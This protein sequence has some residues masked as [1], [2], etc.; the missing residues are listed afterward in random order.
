VTT[1]PLRLRQVLVNLIGNAVKFTEHG[2]VELGVSCGC[3]PEMSATLCFEVSDTGIGIT[4][5]QL[6]KL[7]QPFNQADETMTRRFGGSGLGLSISH[8][9]TR[10]LGG[11]IS[12]SS[13]YRQGST[14]TVRV[15]AGTIDPKE[16]IVS[17]DESILS[18]VVRAPAAPS[19]IRLSGRLLLAEDGRDNQRLITTH[20]RNAGADVTIADNGRIAVDLATT[21]R[22]DLILM[23]MQMPEMDGYAATSELR[24]RG[25]TLPIVA[26][27]AHA[28]AEDRGKCLAAG[29]TDY[30]TKPVEKELLLA[31]VRSYI[32]PPP[33]N[34]HPTLRSAFADDKDM[35]DVLAEFIRGLPAQVKQ[36][37][38]M[39]W[40]SDAVALKRAVHQLKGAGGGYGFPSV[41]ELAG[42]AE[43]QI[44]EGQSVAAVEKQVRE[45][46]DVIRS[47]EGFDEEST[48]K[49]GAEKAVVQ[50]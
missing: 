10:L 43:Q 18:S 27:T 19:E 21:Q 28:M 34:V 24:R 5:D 14:F 15:D 1:D 40:E 23:D 26:L 48:G 2:K 16:M 32:N 35:T 22:F 31:T 36:I 17:P 47:I 41:T 29:C 12:A 8:R 33:P 50:P 44:I 6:T 25:M 11:T 37:E 7:F 46:I 42:S 45:L 38:Q 30:L 9:L 4:R 3:S 13:E 49:Q 20:L 39:L